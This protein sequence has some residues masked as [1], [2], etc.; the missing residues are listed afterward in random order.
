MITYY[1]LEKLFRVTEN[2]DFFAGPPMQTAQAV[3]KSAVT[4]FKNWLASLKE[5]NKRPEKFLGK[6]KMPGYKN[7]ISVRL[8]SAT[9]MWCYTRRRPVYR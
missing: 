2:Q 7:Q 1:Q 5:Y 3:V 4:D 8:P 9:R 6:P